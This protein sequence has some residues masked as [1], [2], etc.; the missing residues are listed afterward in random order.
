MTT[1]KGRRRRR[2]TP[3]PTPRPPAGAGA[4]VVFVGAGPGD[5]RLLT[6]EGASL[7]ERADVL[8]VGPGAGDQARALVPE[9]TRVVEVAAAADLVDA[10]DS[11]QDTP[12][13]LVVRLLSGDGSALS[14]EAT[15]VARLGRSFEVVPGVS[16]TTAV[17]LYAGMPVPEHLR[18]TSP[19][20]AG[21]G[22]ELLTQ[23]DALL[24]DGLDPS[25]PV[26]ITEHGTTTRQ[27]TQVGTLGDA[28]GML[29]DLLGDP[30]VGADAG[31]LPL[32]AV[33]GPAVEQRLELSW[34]ETLPLFGWDVLVPRTKDQSGTAIA[35]LEG[36][37]ATAHVVPTIAVEPPRMPQLVDKAVQG[38]VSGRYEWVG[39]TSAN[40]VRAIREKFESYGLDAR[41]FSGLKIAAVGGATARALQEW[42]LAADLVPSGEQSAA[43]LLEEW[44]PFDD[45]LDP[46]NRVLLPRADIATEPLVIGLTELGWEV[47]DVT[48]YR[49]VRAAPPP[50][51]VREAIK[52]GD[53]DAVVFTSSSTVRNLVGIAGKP[54][55]VTVVACI[56]QATARTAEEHG[57]TVHVI[58]QESSAQSLVDGL[59]EFG[60]GLAL[61]AYE[62]GEQVR[63]P[64]QRRRRR[65]ETTA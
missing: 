15:T 53:F 30:A 3:A 6:V 37:G 47:D 12:G 56:G 21:V 10:I 28:P 23:L 24:A 44:P 41:S 1:A 46:I 58:A 5:P 18:S 4:R 27:R 16:P 13:G 39:F 11:L 19:V 40:A 25:T 8:A 42:G 38:M 2:S 57:L 61:E 49:T 22:P 51:P 26:A 48:A 59:A 9:S 31:A 45:L 14:D 64:S 62:R 36:Y 50:A 34:F 63:R 55:K 29:D 17:P 20:L 35:A 60:Y 65:R 52:S 54:H 43:G 7:L 32:V 33:V